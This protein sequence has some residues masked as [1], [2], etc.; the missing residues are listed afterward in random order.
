VL[1]VGCGSGAFLYPAW[2]LGAQ[3]S[4][5]DYSWQLV[6]GASRALPEGC[7]VQ[8]EAAALPLPAAEFS[9]VLCHSVF[10]YFASEHY[11]VQAIREMQRVLVPRAGR[12]AILDI[13]D[14]EKEDAFYQLRG[15]QIGHEEYREKYQ[16]YPHRFY[17]KEWFARQFAAAGMRVEIEDQAI[18]GYGNSAFRFNVYAWGDS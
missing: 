17:R 11:A 13:N 2:Q 6:K 8:A 5:V 1:E 16:D 7:F 18:P 4:G 9:L 15:E 14:S 3:V 10:Q 12:M